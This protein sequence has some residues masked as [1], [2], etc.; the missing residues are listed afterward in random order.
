MLDKPKLVS[1]IKKTG[2]G[3]LLPGARLQLLDESGNVLYSWTTGADTSNVFRLGN[4][5]YRIH[6]EYAPENYELAKDIEFEVT[7]DTTEVEYVMTAGSFVGS[8]PPSQFTLFPPWSV[9]CVPSI[10]L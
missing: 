10:L 6:E 1:I 8:F 7:D 4:G 9:N 3:D 2:S 5:K